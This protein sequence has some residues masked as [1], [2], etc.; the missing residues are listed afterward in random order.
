M[1]SPAKPVPV[2]YQVNK[3]QPHSCAQAPQQPALLVS[4]YISS[5]LFSSDMAIG[6]W[7]AVKSRWWQRLLSGLG[8]SWEKQSDLPEEVASYF[9][10]LQEEGK[11][12]EASETF[13][14]GKEL[15]EAAQPT[16][17]CPTAARERSPLGLG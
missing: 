14:Q 10:C 2:S 3:S 15:S 12:W 17:F 7:G 11:V 9:F 13:W 8:S 4:L 1:T 16:R 6:S 5:A